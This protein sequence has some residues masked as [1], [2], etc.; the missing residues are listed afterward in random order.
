MLD[1]TTLFSAIALV[2]VIEGLLLFAGP[3]AMKKMYADAALL[4]HKMLRLIGLGAIIAGV[5]IL[6]FIR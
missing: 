3:E 6:Y 4:D 5:V 1:W 2:F